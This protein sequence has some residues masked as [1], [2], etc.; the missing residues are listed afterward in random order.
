MNR[1]KKIQNIVQNPDLEIIGGS[2]LYGTS[3]DG[4][5]EDRRGFF[6]QPYFSMM[7]FYKPNG[8]KWGCKTIDKTVDGIDYHVHPFRKFLKYCLKCNNNFVEILFVPEESIIN[9]SDF[10]KMVIEN[11]D[12]LLSKKAFAPF[13]GFAKSEFMKITGESTRDLGKK[14]KEHIE[15]HGYAV[16]NAYHSIRIMSQGA[17]LLREGHITFPRPEKDILMEIRNG[18]VSFEDF[19]DIYC[20]SE[21]ELKQAMEKSVLPEHPDYEFANSLIQKSIDIA[22]SRGE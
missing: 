22:R 18:E 1:E 15:K 6:I 3:V 11:R 9:V 17:E 5:D 16:K 14:R 21:N 19:K 4:S 8:G 10:G 20:D 2:H 7:G 13:H 12:K